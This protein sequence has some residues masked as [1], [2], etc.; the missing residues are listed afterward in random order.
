MKRS[1]RDRWLAENRDGY[2][3][4][5]GDADPWLAP[6]ISVGGQ[7]QVQFWKRNENHVIFSR[8]LEYADQVTASETLVTWLGVSEVE[9]RQ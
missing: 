9:I 6:A 3:N 4:V 7:D 8:S 1:T 5:Y 2:V